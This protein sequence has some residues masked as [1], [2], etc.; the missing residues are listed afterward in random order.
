[1]AKP[2]H[3]IPELLSSAE[4]AKVLNTSPKAIRTAHSR[5][6]L[7]RGIRLPGVRGLRWRGEDVA[8]WIDEHARTKGAAA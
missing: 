2:T 3:T 4:L 6:L 7:P 1:M 8:R 5:G